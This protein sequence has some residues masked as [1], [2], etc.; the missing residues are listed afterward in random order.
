MSP[1]PEI[2]HISLVTLPLGGAFD[3]HS[4]PLLLSAFAVECVFSLRCRRGGRCRGRMTKFHVLVY[5]IVSKCTGSDCGSQMSSSDIDSV[6]GG[7]S[8][9][10]HQHE[11]LQ[12]KST[13]NRPLAKGVH[14]DSG[15]RYT[16]GW[17]Q[18][19]RERDTGP[20]NQVS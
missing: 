19:V 8:Q 15:R 3:L 6:M 17:R 14:Q 13:A 9:V 18:T 5:Q 10:C 16:V 7:G 1:N 20:N 4:F 11:H 2:H 12:S